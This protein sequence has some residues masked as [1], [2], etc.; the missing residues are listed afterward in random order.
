MHPYQKVAIVYG[1]IFLVTFF[2][3]QLYSF[4]HPTL[5]QQKLKTIS[6]KYKFYLNRNLELAEK[7]LFF[8]AGQIFGRKFKHSSVKS[9]HFEC[10]ALTAFFWFFRA[11]RFLFRLFLSNSFALTSGGSAF[12]RPW[13]RHHSRNSLHFL[14]RKN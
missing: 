2:F 10:D 13:W 7:K 8:D 1:Q 14:L 4:S 5:S 9:T 6:S 3:I 12:R 11:R